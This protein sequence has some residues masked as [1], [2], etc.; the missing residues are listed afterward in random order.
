L[1]EDQSFEV[2]LI[3]QEAISDWVALDKSVALSRKIESARRQNFKE[4]NH[5]RKSS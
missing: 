2:Q 3:P 4:A 5:G 1:K